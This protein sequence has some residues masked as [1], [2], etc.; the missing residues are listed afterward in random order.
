[1][2]LIIGLTRM[3]ICKGQEGK[4]PA[5]NSFSVIFIKAFTLLFFLF[6]TQSISAQEL[7][8]VT[9]VSRKTNQPIPFA[10]VKL[11]NTISGT[12]SD[13]N[14]K[15]S[16]LM[17]RTDTLL[18]SSVGYIPLKVVSS[19]KSGRTIFL[20]PYIHLLEQVSVTQRKLT[21]TKTLGIK[22]NVDVNWGA[23][24]SGEEFAQLINL[25][26]DGGDVL[27]IRKVIIPSG[28]FNSTTPA[29][30]HI[31]SV[32][33]DTG[34]PGNEL[35]ENQYL[36][37]EKNFRR[38]QII[39]DLTQEDFFTNEKRIF[40]SC[41]FLGSTKTTV[42]RSGLGTSIFMTFSKPQSYTFSRTLTHANYDWFSRQHFNSK[43]KEYVNALNT[44]YLIEVEQY[45]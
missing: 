19:A 40:V 10:T 30:L 1:M 20:E 22:G 39:I 9:L 15:F 31:Y 18:I 45:K 33:E 2:E 4:P 14:G 43:G 11:L 28:G 23:S 21:G 26:Q 41:E 17:N 8:S 25:P 32:N 16:L 42:K 27:K 7:I 38:K 13:E 29:V 5:S 12:Y 35:L 3:C 36:I 37:T 44:M 6:F 34:L 24:G